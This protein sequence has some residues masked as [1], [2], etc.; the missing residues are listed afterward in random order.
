MQR[1]QDSV[2]FSFNDFGSK[3]RSPLLIIAFSH[4]LL[5]FGRFNLSSGG[6]LG[7]APMSCFLESVKYTVVDWLLWLRLY[8]YIDSEIML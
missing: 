3:T 6:R 7:I 1:R 5:L 4:I 8:R 2:T